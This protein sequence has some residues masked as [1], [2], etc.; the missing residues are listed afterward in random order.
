MT[1]ALGVLTQRIRDRDVTLEL[2]LLGET[3][4][5]DCHFLCITLLLDLLSNPL[6]N[7]LEVEDALWAE[8]VAVAAKD[9]GVV[10]LFGVL[11]GLEQ[12]EEHFANIVNV[13][14]IP[15][16]LALADERRE[17]FPQGHLDEGRDL[18]RML[19]AGTRALAEDE[20]GADDGRLDRVGNGSL[21]NLV[22][23]SVGGSVV[24]V[25]DAVDVV[26]VVVFLV[27]QGRLA[28]SAVDDVVPG[29]DACAG[30]VN[31]VSGLLG[32]V[33][34]FQALGDGGGTGGMV[35]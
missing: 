24:E 15:F 7:L 1:H 11:A 16:G 2:L 10:L 25:E 6:C 26:D 20:R 17:A 33:A 28:L 21:D 29:Q 35:G 23:V 30:E 12:L 27:R 14:V 31:P 34:L 5:L 22:D 8:E 32:R 9:L 4:G 3:H 18:D 19:V 13:Y